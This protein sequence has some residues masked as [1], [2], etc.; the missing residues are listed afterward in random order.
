MWVCLG[1][2][3]SLSLVLWLRNGYGIGVVSGADEA[4]DLFLCR[5]LFPFFF[6]RIVERAGRVEAG[7]SGDTEAACG[8]HMLPARSRERSGNAAC[9]AS[10]LSLNL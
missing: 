5:I 6:P 1:L 10:Y 8:K 4:Y 7:R 9:V 2:S 3:L